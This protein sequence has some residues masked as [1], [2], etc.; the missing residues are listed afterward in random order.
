MLPASPVEAL[1][2]HAED[3]QAV[4][5][6]AVASRH[7]RSAE[8][9]EASGSRYAMGFGSQWLDLLVDVHEELHGRGYRTYRLPPAGYRLPVVNECLVYVWRVPGSA[10]TASSFASSPTRVNGFLAPPL[11]PTLFE[12]G[13]TGELE[14][15][16][17]SKGDAGLERVVRAAGAVMP[18]VLVM[19]EST[20]RQLQSIAWAVAKLDKATGEVKQHG[21]ENIWVPE[22]S[23]KNAA[24][25]VE[26][27]DSGRPEGPTVEPQEQEG[28]QPDA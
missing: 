10:D 13:F 7:A 26:P 4:V 16:A 21:R 27:F 22:V 8:A 20:P 18:L 12:P 15:D 23:S 28:N 19:V 3:V 17:N 2:S 9:H 11:D 5:V 6:A 14:Q 25:E 1:G 24:T